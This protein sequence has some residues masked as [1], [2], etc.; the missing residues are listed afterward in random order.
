VTVVGRVRSAAP[1]A[2]LLPRAR[3]VF[4]TFLLVALAIQQLVLFGA[5]TSWWPDRA[6]GLAAVAVVAA[7]CL[8]VVRSQRAPLVGDA[9]VVA[10]LVAAGLSGGEDGSVLVLL[11]AVV[12]VR[13]LYGRRQ[14]LAAVVVALLAGF[15]TVAIV[16][17]GGAEPL[18][19]GIVTAVLIA[20]AATLRR[21]MELLGEH[22][23]DARLDAVA[24][25]TA[26][27]LMEATTTAEVDDVEQAALA[28]IR[29]HRAAAERDPA[30][31]PVPTTVPDR[32]AALPESSG[33]DLLDPVA[34][35]LRRLASDTFLARQRVGSETRYRAV[36]EGSRDGIY[37]RTI[38]PE[39]S[40]R[41]LNPAAEAL[42]GADVG[43]LARDRD[44]VTRAIHPDDLVRVLDV[45]ADHGHLVD[46]VEVRLRRTDGRE[47]WVA[48]QERIVEVDGDARTVLGTITDVTQHHETE[49]ALQRIAEREHDAAEE[50]RHLDA[51]KS[52]FLQAVS[53]ELR[54]PLSA[55]IGAAQTLDT[56]DQA[57]D[58]DQRRRMLD[59]VQRQSGRL[60]RLL[61]DLLDVD[62]LSRGLVAPDRRPVD[63]HALAAGV[64]ETFDG[65]DRI[66]LVGDPVVVHV[67][68]PK[69]E[70]IVDN[71]LR[72][73]LRHTPADS[74]IRC[75][76][77][78]AAGGATIVVEDE[79]PG[80]PDELK[81][82]LFRP[83]TQ[84]PE[85]TAAPS[86]GTGIGL[87]LVRALAEMH[88]G[89]A[90]VEDRPGG[91]ARFGVWL[92]DEAPADAPVDAT[93]E[94][95]HEVPVDAQG[96]APVDEVAVVVDVTDGPPV[97]RS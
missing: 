38:D 22:D 60:E 7:W 46:A 95:P 61:T 21:V 31:R 23:L 19:F 79:G 2:L 71:L 94:A 47:R 54:T 26:A 64:L 85:A 44:L 89:R 48:L 50:L 72:N 49:T 10:A 9:L 37:L 70:R 3:T 41:Y 32:L 24:T 55:V 39:P 28:S 51:M 36:A 43:Q 73:A 30:A 12:P 83:F 15:A 74:R 87:A 67:D 76:V 11:F 5:G 96:A 63:I 62:R 66:E 34:A 86:P 75:H 65:E 59:I 14:E 92:P 56:H 25:A 58:D 35:V 27:A 97:A 78:L 1:R 88:G 69:V 57:M 42:L 20:T 8:V 17:H 77:V 40:Y 18:E 52:T 33:A 6:I 16:A 90:W 93:V 45:V 4:A 80:V 84:G 81:S 68:G 53:H 82:E 29:H 13:A 91:G